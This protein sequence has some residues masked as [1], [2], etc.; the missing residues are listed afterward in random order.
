M[1]FIVESTTIRF[2]DYCQIDKN[3]SHDDPVIVCGSGIAGALLALRISA[4]G[5]V[6]LITKDA[7]GQSNT[8][9][10]QGGIAAAIAADDSID[11]HISDTLA[12]GAGLCDR[13]IVADLCAAGPACVASL[14]KIGVA[15]DGEP[16]HPRLSLEGAHSANRVIHSGGDATGRSIAETLVDAVRSR[17]AITVHERHIAIEVVRHDG[18]ARGVRSISPDGTE[19]LHLG[20]AVVLAAGGSGHLYPRTTNPLGATGDGIAMAGRAGAALADLEFIQFHPTA[21]ALGANPLSLIS[22]AVRGAGAVLRAD[23]GSRLFGPDDDLDE[24]GPRDRVARAIFRRARI[25]GA[26]VTL[27]LTHL[28]RDDVYAKFPTIVGICA[29]HGLDLARDPIPVSPAAHY[30]MGGV[31]SDLSGRSTVPG[32]FVIG[33]CSST[34]AHGAN[35]LASN[36]LLEAAVMADRAADLL[37]GDELVWPN[38]PVADAAPLAEPAPGGES[39]FR[40]DLQAAMWA[41]AGLERDAAGLDDADRSLRALGPAPSWEDANLAYLADLTVA[42]CRIRT[43]S[44][45]GHFRTDHPDADI[46]LVHRIGWV[47]STPIEIPVPRSR[48]P[49]EVTA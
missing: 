24:L 19:R 17:D 29:E 6:V 10:A 39:T 26:D 3:V 35:R 27:D 1:A 40:D 38:G 41:G 23:D 20:R 44:R 30:A 12:A 32:L 11:S 5:P 49:E 8:R 45:G 43:E 34:G 25:D 33:E 16:G 37:L 36:S 9:H 4:R 14:S 46:N 42:A 31:L 47:G 28:D 15:F 18:V 13:E 21:L 7:L 2:M 48:V 22:E